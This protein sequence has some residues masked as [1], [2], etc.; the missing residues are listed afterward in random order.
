MAMNKREIAFTGSKKG[1]NK[2]VHPLDKKLKGPLIQ[3]ACC[4]L[5][6]Q[7]LDNQGIQTLLHQSLV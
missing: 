6:I 1:A 2:G 3:R 4:T 7:V 5:T